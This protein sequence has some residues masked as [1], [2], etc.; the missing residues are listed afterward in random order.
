[1]LIIKEFSLKPATL[2]LN[3]DPEG[4]SM[5]ENMDAASEC[6]RKLVSAT[7]D[8]VPRHARAGHWRKAIP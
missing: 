2:S 6:P 4:A 5:E 8:Q 1:M 7:H 3:R